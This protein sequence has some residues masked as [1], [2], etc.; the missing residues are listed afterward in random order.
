MLYERMMEPFIIMEKKKV[1][2]GE[3]GFTTTWTDGLTVNLALSSNT[4]MQAR[5][6]EHEGVTSTCTITSY[7]NVKLDFH[8]VVKRVSDGMMYRVTSNSGV[9]ESP[10]FSSID[11]NQVTAEKWEMPNE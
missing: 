7:K 11:M 9:K 8:D 1:S 3:G 10:N 5:I 6:A 4:S 2:D